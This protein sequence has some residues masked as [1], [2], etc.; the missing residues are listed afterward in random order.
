M[1]NLPG[2]LG[3]QPSA[4]WISKQR[5]DTS[6]A[7]N[8]VRFA[9]DQCVMGSSEER[10]KEAEHAISTRESYLGLHDALR[11]DAPPKECISWVLGPEQMSAPGTER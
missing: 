4:T 6:L 5:K 10:V 11:K 3:Y 8:M 7:S 9:D 1:L 2:M